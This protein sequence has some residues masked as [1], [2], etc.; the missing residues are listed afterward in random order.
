LVVE[1]NEADV[2]LIVSA[3][4]DSGVHNQ[5]HIVTDG[6]AALAFLKQTGVHADAPRPDLV[7]LDLN[8]PKVDGFD[9]LAKM[10]AD[11]RLNKIPVVIISGSDSDVDLA[12]AY[13]MHVSSY[14]IKPPHPDQFIAAIR[15]MDLW[16]QTLALSPKQSE[17]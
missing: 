13:R 9:V 1:D 2:F 15:A 4:R 7:L 10:K 3:F 14:L 8:L 11:P 12:R 5:L 16:L 6:D 17:A